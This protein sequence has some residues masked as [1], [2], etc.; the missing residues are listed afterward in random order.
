MIDVVKLLDFCEK[1]I[2][3][4]VHVLSEYLYDYIIY[5]S[6]LHKLDLI[7]CSFFF[8]IIFFQWKEGGSE[9]N[10]PSPIFQGRLYLITENP[11]TSLNT[12]HILKKYI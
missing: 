11:D 1:H 3:F 6:Q 7:A 2:Q 9:Q 8:K 5:K 10:D 4:Y 12:K